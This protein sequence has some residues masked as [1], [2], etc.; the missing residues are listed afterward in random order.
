MGT[1]ETRGRK[2]ARKRDLQRAI[3][4]TVSAA[5]LL[6]IALVAPNMPVALK[7]LGML[8][9]SSRDAGSI[10]RARN[11]LLRKG[12]LSRSKD[13]F[14]ELTPAGERALLLAQSGEHAPKPRRWDGR[15]RVLIFDIPERRRT[16]RDK[17]RLMLINIGFVLLQ[18]SVWVYPYDCE[19]VVALLKAE[20][21]IGKQMLYLIVD[22]MEGD[23]PLRRRFGLS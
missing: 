19:H 20:L 10:N 13:G 4:G 23:A 6:A 7:K 9:T 18:G 3:L 22:E 12:L 17:T 11:H 14:L 15:W 2:R 1:I 21:K 16:T 5:G 8:P